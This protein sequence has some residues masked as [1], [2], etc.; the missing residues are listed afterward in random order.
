MTLHAAR[1]DNERESAMTTN[2]TRLYQISLLFFASTFIAGC[3]AIA[4][5]F[6]AGFWVGAIGVLIVLGL[7]FFIF[8]RGRS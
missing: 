1:H 7:L 8:G 5:I 2:A 6:Q 3:E 4:G